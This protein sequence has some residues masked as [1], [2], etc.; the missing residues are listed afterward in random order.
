MVRKFLPWISFP[1]SLTNTWPS[2]AFRYLQ[3]KYS[4]LVVI[5]PGPFE[6]WM[7][8]CI[9]GCECCLTC[10][11]IWLGIEGPMPWSLKALPWFRCDAKGISYWLSVEPP[12]S[13]WQLW[14]LRKLSITSGIFKVSTTMGLQR[15]CLG[16]VINGQRMLENTQW[17]EQ[18]DGPVT[19]SLQRFMS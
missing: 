4:F 1:S 19:C 2:P 18:G 8:P 12:S 6:L 16:P 10:I 17:R 11:E 5:K 9:D 15:L 3:L 13:F 14:F 7:A